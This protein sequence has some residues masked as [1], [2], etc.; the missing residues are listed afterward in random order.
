MRVVCVRFASR[1]ADKEGHVAKKKT[2]ELTD[3]AADF[4]GDD[5]DW[6]DEEEEGGT[7]PVAP[8]PESSVQ[9]QVGT[10]G[11]SSE[12]AWANRISD[13]PLDPKHVASAPTL[14][15]SSVPT[16]PPG[17][18]PLAELPRVERSDHAIEDAPTVSDDTA[19]VASSPEEG[20]PPIG[21]VAPSQRIMTPP[22]A[23]IAQPPP[24]K[25]A[26]GRLGADYRAVERYVPPPDD[27]VVPRPAIAR[28]TPAPVE[29]ATFPAEEP[30]QDGPS[31]SWYAP[32]SEEVP[33]D[34][35][36][37]PG[38]PGEAEA[39]GSDL[40]S[41][42]AP[43]ADDPAQQV[44]ALGAAPTDDPGTE[45]VYGDQ[46]E[47]TGEAE[48]PLV[49]PMQGKG[50]EETEPTVQGHTSV[51]EADGGTRGDSDR[52]STALGDA[53]APLERWRPEGEEQD[54]RDAAAAM[55]AE[56]ALGSPSARAQLLFE[57]GDVIATRLGDR[58]GG[59]TLYREAYD[60]GC[61]DR[62][63]LLALVEAALAGER[64]Q[65]AL[66]YL[67]EVAL[68]STG[69][70]RAD[71]EMR[72]ALCAR[73]RL[74][75]F[76]S[77]IH[78]ARRALEADP[79]CY[80]ALT[81]LRD[82]LSDP[83]AGAD[84]AAVLGRL[85]Q[86]SD[87]YLAAETWVEQG[88]LL[89]ELGRTDDARTALESALF[90]CPSHTEAFAET[91]ALLT[92]L[93]DCAAL[94]N[95]HA[96]EA[97]RSGQED[98][99]W[100]WL[101]SARAHAA[102]GQIEEA[103]SSFLRSYAAGYD[104]A[105]RE[106]AAMWLREGAH[107]R[108][109]SALSEEAERCEDIRPWAL[110]CIGAVRERA[111]GDA[112][113]ALAAYRA[114]LEADPS[115]GPA[116][117]GLVRVLRS[118]GR[119]PEVMSF[120]ERVLD[121]LP[122]DAARRPV[123]F[124]VARLAE[125]AG[126]DER[127]DRA[128]E[129]LAQGDSGPYAWL[130]LEGRIRA[131]GRME[132]WLELSEVY[133][134]VAVQSASPA[135]KARWLHAAATVGTNSPD[136][137]RAL[138]Y[139]R[140]ALDLVPNHLESLRALERL[141]PD[142]GKIPE[143]ARA[144]GRAAGVTADPAHQVALAFRAAEQWAAV[145]QTDEAREAAEWCIERAPEFEPALWLLVEVAAPG[146]RAD[147]YRRWA[148]RASTPS[149]RAWHATAAAM[150]TED[151]AARLNDLKRAV[152]ARPDVHGPRLVAEVFALAEGDLPQLT[153]WIDASMTGASSSVQA[154]RSLRLA[155]LL[156]GQNRLD[157]AAHV[158][159]DVVSQSVP[160]RP[161]RAASRIAQMIGAWD[162]AA[163]LLEPLTHPE[164]R[165]ERAR[166]MS[167]K[168]RQAKPALQIL[169]QLGSER[170]GDVAVA[171]V[172]ARAAFQADER[173]GMVR[174]QAVI[175]RH[176]E[177]LPMRAAYAAWTAMMLDAGGREDEALEFWKIA[178]GA[179]PE[180]V[181]AFDGV[182]R[183]LVN[184]GDGEEL[185]GLYAARPA[186]R[187]TLA[188]QL[189]AVEDRFGASVVLAEQVAEGSSEEEGIAALLLLERI[190]TQIEDWAGLYDALVRRR[191]RTKDQ[192]QVARIDAK[193]RW[194]LAEKLADTDE[195][196]DMYRQ[197]HDDDPTD[198]E[199]TEALARIAGARGETALAT[200]YLRALVEG[201]PDAPT[202]ARYQ[203]RI[204]ELYESVGDRAS[205]R[206]AYLDA[207][208]HVNDDTDAMGGLKRLAE[209]DEDWSGMIAVLQRE[210]AIAPPERRLAVRR[211]IAHVTEGRLKDAAVAMD[212]WRAVL[213][214]V[215]QDTDALERLLELA[216]RGHEWGV[217]VETGKQLASLR[218]GAMRS[219][220]LRR[221]GVVCLEQLDRDDA[222]RY[223][224]QAVSGEQPDV[225]AARRLE[226]LYQARSDWNGA[227]RALGVQAEAATSSEERI[228]ALL[229]AARIETETR[230]DRDAAST[231][232]SRILNVD[233]NHEAALRFMATHLF[234][235]HR[236]EE[237]KPI[238][239]RLEPVVEKGQ[240]LDDFDTRMELSTFH[241]YAAE[242]HRLAGS[243]EQA[244]TRYERALTLN[245]THLASLEAAGPLYIELKQWKKAEK[246]LRQL[247]QLTGGQGDRHKA[248]T[249]YAQL[250][251]VELALGSLDKASKRFNKALEIF[252]NHVAALKGLA[253]VL[254]QQ[255]DWNNLLTI[256]NN[257]I[258][259]ATVPHD[260][261]DAYMTKGRILDDRMAR[262]DKAAQH[263]QR[264]LDFDG[265]Q[266][267]AH[268]RL[269]ELAMRRD[270]YQEA[271]AF[272]E[273]ALALVGP[274]VDTVRPFL[275]LC[276]AA[277][278]ADAGRM[279]DA[280]RRVAEARQLG[281]ARMEGLPANITSDLE[282]L[283]RFVKDR[284]P[285]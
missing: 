163:N 18:S 92:E 155:E 68:Q 168:L 284:L 107:E 221:V 252:P 210:A 228:D 230:H 267:V 154:R 30:A 139:H 32:P 169:E 86:A 20:P 257:I 60:A 17:P 114:C 35:A 223:F 33:T 95:L 266:A 56:A 82:L 146:H 141:L 199:V 245:P 63:L 81:L 183:G 214:L 21:P 259:H 58:S 121:A 104:F 157:E 274:D 73:D 242:M 261:I 253:M 12:E 233:P 275:L 36:M 175:A 116:A 219:S 244:L 217:F 166:L 237:A 14:T 265:D 160:D 51:D 44:A 277:A 65:D 282:G 226:A 224:E 247:L 239:E 111:L 285:T 130:A 176:A 120:L 75:R 6:L 232:Y 227:V 240:D 108:F 235:S 142:A 13:A 182:A 195:A 186:L 272:A 2:P 231:Y 119:T 280:E 200:Q 197:L 263:Y 269:A 37:L 55:L 31:S 72:A 96:A 260:V 170:P 134:R 112:E 262:P 62:R 15:F 279:E 79:T 212:A 258:Y 38:A 67:D 283:R 191:E 268:L 270:A 161:L 204:G 128:W 48:T 213:D 89:R 8:P 52:S 158:L 3:A 140:Q 41:V 83:S 7:L 129:D 271:G 248:A 181:D 264:S 46:L 105:N 87:G 222:I 138:D 61:R 118:L 171:I 98:P 184:R 190:R 249:T 29:R 194:L 57:A 151:P 26:V 109:A 45:E 251:Q 19:E 238:C 207:L 162:H 91:V 198:R 156:S 131:L 276:A 93:G 125:L 144:L 173:D 50:W 127:A 102:A 9:P 76:E 152:E 80:P 39:Q 85:A 196:W 40:A 281:K 167:R 25:A 78:H 208:D 113:G 122:D 117:G 189:E 135:E 70:A 66:R 132:R 69:A 159:A 246:S 123:L 5:V 133:A 256:Y 106:L 147:A 53:Q 185:R 49:R 211:E 205:A 115:S 4:F 99:G 206:Q 34:V 201:S 187:A 192:P 179:R 188:R 243:G 215:P 216:E 101:A 229:R 150:L 110:F 143:V 174:A 100:S 124:Q 153:E 145:E 59:E 234:E 1:E 10:P 24:S 209:L 77:A 202:S 90:A 103:S 126:D 164:D 47:Y 11:G 180:C 273:R 149:E 27:G 278:D 193:R 23:P 16:L 137:E 236:F 203:R 74:K 22:L 241:F 64:D 177:S 250:G 220:L 54:W 43:E 148:D 254:E 136:R 71:L 178:L 225:E 28:V 172:A 94:A 255:E 218:A 84:R 88:R 165:L 42:Q 97:S